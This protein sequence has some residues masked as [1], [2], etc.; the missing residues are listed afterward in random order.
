[1]TTG[2]RSTVN[3]ESSGPQMDVSKNRGTP[4]WMVYNGKPLLKF[5]IWGYPYFWKHPNSP[6]RSH[7][8]CERYQP[9]Y[10]ENLESSERK[11]RR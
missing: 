4:K 5:M 11:L 7:T 10:L 2:K 6:L 1:M 3:L 9:T 8:F